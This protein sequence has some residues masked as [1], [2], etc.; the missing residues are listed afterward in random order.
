[1]LKVA[2]ETGRVFQTG[3]Q[4]RSDKRFRMA[5]ELVRNGRI[6]KV[7]KVEAH[8]PGAPK[9]GPFDPQPVPE[10]LDWQMWLGPAPERE[11][12]PQR[13]HGTFRWFFDYSGGMITDWGAH[14]LDIAQWA[15]G[16]D[17]SGPVRIEARGDRPASDWTFR[18]YDVFPAFDITYT[19]PEGTTLLCTNKG[20]NGVRFEGE[21]GKWIFVS[22]SKIEASD[23]ALLSDPLPEGAVRLYASDSH[24]QDWLDCIRSR[25]RPICDVEIGHRSASVCHLGNIALRVN[26]GAL[27]WDPKKEEFKNSK[28]A[29][30]LRTRPMRGPWSLV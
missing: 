3:S 9:G 25:Q 5:C 20:E 23:P 27:E 19:Y 26:E 21:G 4:Q 30:A 15:L 16:K 7:T 17:A 8:L 11:Y 22:R 10:G 14:H 18:S 13:V 1:M 29:N 28:P 12:M 2:R 6:G 24:E